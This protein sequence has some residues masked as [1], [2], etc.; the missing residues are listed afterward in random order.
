[1]EVAFSFRV[2]LSGNEM[3]VISLGLTGRLKGPMI[4]AAHDLNT[5]LLAARHKA[6]Q[7]AISADKAMANRNNENKE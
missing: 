2:T 5:R 6:L 3:K 4:Q 1:M 7:D